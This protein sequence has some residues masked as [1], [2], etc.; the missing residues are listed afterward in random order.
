MIDIL[1]EILSRLRPLKIVRWFAVVA[2]CLLLWIVINYEPLREYFTMR[3]K[4]GSYTQTNDQLERERNDLAKE[5]DALQAGGFPAEKAIREK[6]LMV[7]P[8]EKV[9]VIESD[10]QPTTR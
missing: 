7:K 5:H 9:Y 2:A 3:D 6:L 8:G 1:V 4:L 10:D